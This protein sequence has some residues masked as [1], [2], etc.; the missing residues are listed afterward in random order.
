MKTTVI[1]FLTYKIKEAIF[2]KPQDK[3]Y[4]GIIVIGQHAK[5]ND[6]M[7]IQLKEKL[8][9]ML[10]LQEQMKALLNLYHQQMSFRKCFR[11]D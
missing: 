7:L 2:I 6:L 11:V 4:V 1:Q 5:D 9:Q 10:N 8:N 3:V